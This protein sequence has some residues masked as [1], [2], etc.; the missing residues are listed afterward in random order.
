MANGINS[1]FILLA[2]PLN[3]KRGLHVIDFPTMEQDADKSVW[4]LT[5]AELRERWHI[6]WGF[7]R[8]WLHRLLASVDIVDILVHDSLHTY[9]NMQRE[10]GT[11]SG[12]LVHPSHLL[13]DD[14]QDSPAFHE[15]VE[16]CRPA[17]SLVVAE[18][19]KQALFRIALMSNANPNR[20]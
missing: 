10:L 11:I 16:E 3:A 20:S 15:W 17:P 8:T 2:L 1:D 12:R 5:P 4:M 7:S 18:A 14:I 19:Q 9:R 13:A 6:L